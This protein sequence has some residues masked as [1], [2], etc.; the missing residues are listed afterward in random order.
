[1]AILST[2]RPN[3][4]PGEKA[5]CRALCDWLASHAITHRIHTFTQYPYYFEFI[6]VWII[7]SRTLLATAIWFHWG[8][9]AFA[10]ALV[11]LI[12]GAV[13][14]AFRIPL[15]CWPGSCTGR[16][17]LIEFEPA[18]VK[19]E[20]IISAHYDSK[21]ELLDHRQRM[22]F[23]KNV[24]LG[25]FLTFLLGVFGPLDIY[26]QNRNASLADVVYWCGVG[27]TIILLI[28][29]WGLGL[30]LSIG[31]L[32]PQSPGAADNGAACAILL[33]LAHE[34]AGGSFSLKNTRVTL[35]L[36]T[37]EEINMQGSRAYVL[38]RAWD[39]PATG[40]N[41]EAMA[42]NGDYVIWKQDGSIFKLEDTCPRVSQAVARAAQQVTMRK[43]LPAGPIIS[44]GS[45]FLAAG[46]PTAV[47]GTY[48]RHWVDAGF[49]RPTDNL[50][51]VVAERL[52]EG[53][54]ILKQFLR[55]HDDDT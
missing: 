20:V 21:T 38:N 5:T 35:A 30:N 23:L 4:S 32:L 22:F 51:R 36:F 14:V 34:F 12:G 55:G 19:K 43:P 9:W 40:I 33:G 45:S 46:I 49:H 47:L 24:R 25:I 6:G 1:M 42:Q 13:D 15:V 11:G 54:E 29:A 3:G 18:E 17:I 44:D 53:V 41:L 10:I 7:L 39:L 28:L 48:D 37:G 50:S 27:L 26:L 2:P 16:N 52:P 31:R 8:W